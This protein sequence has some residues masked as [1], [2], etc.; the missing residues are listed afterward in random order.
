MRREKESEERGG[1]KQRRWKD[2]EYVY[3][4]KSRKLGGRKARGGRPPVYIMSAGAGLWILKFMVCGTRLETAQF[5]VYFIMPCRLRT[6]VRNSHF[7]KTNHSLNTTSES[8]GNPTV[9]FTFA[10]K[11]SRHQF[12]MEFC[13]W[14]VYFLR[15]KTGKKKKKKREIRCHWYFWTRVWYKVSF[16][17]EFY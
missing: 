6:S 13:P 4:L 8:I 1:N 17:F 5:S 10:S 15:I 9:L 11:Q 7:V 14:A 12:E 16:G 2:G 3:T